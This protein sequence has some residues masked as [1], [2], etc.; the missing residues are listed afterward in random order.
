VQIG[1]LPVL[2][3]ATDHLPGKLCAK[4][5]HVNYLYRAGE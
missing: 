3:V 5:C 2:V 4:R 1:P